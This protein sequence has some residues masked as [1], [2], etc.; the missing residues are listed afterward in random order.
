M[1]RSSGSVLPDPMRELQK[2]V[3]H[4]I[5]ASRTIRRTVG[6]PRRWHVKGASTD[7]GD[8]AG[9]RTVAQ[10]HVGYF[11]TKEAKL[12]ISWENGLPDKMG[13]TTT[14]AWIQESGGG[15]DDKAQHLISRCGDGIMRAAARCADTVPPRIGSQRLDRWAKPARQRG[16]PHQNCRQLKKDEGR[17]VA[18]QRPGAHG[19]LGCHRRDARHHRAKRRAPEKALE[20]A[21]AAPAGRFRGLRLLGSIAQ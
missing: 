17:V 12:S 14:L 13:S 2:Q 1:A 19:P 21:R 11:Q 4:P 16:A 20:D 18:I 15:R 7:E 9:M 5:S 10:C 8:P 3:N 6:R